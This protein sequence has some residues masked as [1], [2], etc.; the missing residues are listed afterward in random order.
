MQALGIPGEATVEEVLEIPLDV[1]ERDLR[2]KA[3]I[4]NPPV[5][6]TGFQIGRLRRAFCDA[7]AEAKGPEPLAAPPATAA[8]TAPPAAPIYLPT[9]EDPLITRFSLVLSQTV[10]G[11]FHP[12]RTLWLQRASS[13]G[14]SSATTPWRTSAPLTASPLRWRRGWSPSRGDASGCRR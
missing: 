6:L 8:A 13:T 5:P 10:P 2:N 3:I 12:F 11:S 14:T 7:L 9:S 1:V 4:G